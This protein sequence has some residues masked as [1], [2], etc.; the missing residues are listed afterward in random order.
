MA[1]KRSPVICTA[2]DMYI[3]QNRIVN[4]TFSAPLLDL[5]VTEG[6]FSGD[7]SGNIP[8]YVIR[9]DPRADLFLPHF[10]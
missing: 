8:R 1:V 10:T 4:Q 9:P 5:K 2:E 6:T 3:F 7:I